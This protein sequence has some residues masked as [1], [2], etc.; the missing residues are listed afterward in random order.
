MKKYDKMIS[1]NE[2]LSREKINRAINAIIEMEKEGG[3]FSI[4]E[5]TRRT[6]LSRSFFYKN[7]K[8]REKLD[9]ALKSYKNIEVKSQRAQILNGALQ[10]R[11][12]LLERELD[13]ALNKNATLEKE[14]FRLNRVVGQLEIEL[15]RAL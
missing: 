6:G 9:L 3:D 14:N 10:A 11:V 4:T 13:A 15:L 8:V 7:T 12:K 5:L 2:L 1:M